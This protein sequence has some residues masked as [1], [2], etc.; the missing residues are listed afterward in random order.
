MDVMNGW[1]FVWWVTD[2]KGIQTKA[3]SQAVSGKKE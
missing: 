1:D 3:Q 2:D